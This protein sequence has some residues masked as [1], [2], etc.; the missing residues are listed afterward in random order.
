MRENI[1]QQALSCDNTGTPVGV[2]TDIVNAARSSTTPDVGAYEFTG[3]VCTSPPTAGNSVASLPSICSNGSVTLDLAG[4]TSGTGQTYQWQS[5]SAINGTYTNIS[6]VLANPAFT[7]SPTSTLFYKAVVTCNSLFDKS[8]A[9]Q[10]TVNP[11]LAS[12][13]YTIDP[14]GSGGFNFTTLTQAVDAL[15]CGIL[16]PV[17]FNVQPGT[18]NEQVTI[19][20]VA[21][22]SATNTVT[23]NGNGASIVFTSANTN[24]RA[25]ITLD[26]ADYI[27]INN[28]IINGS[29]GTYGW[30]I[31]LLNGADYNIISNN[32]INVLN[33]TNTAYN[34]LGICIGGTFTTPISASNAGNY[35]TISGNT[36]TGGY[37]PVVFYGSS[38][39]PYNTDNKVFNNIVKD[40]YSY[41]IYVYGNV[42]GIISRNDISRPTKAASTTT[43]GVFLSTGSSGMLVDKNTIH[44]MFDG[45][46]AGTSIFYGIYTSGLATVGNENKITNNLIYTPNGNGAV[47]GIYNST[48]PYMQAYHNT[49]SID[50]A[51]ATSGAAYGIYQTGAATGIDLRNNVISITRGGTGIKRC[52]YFVT[53]TSTITSN[54]NDLY[55]NSPGGTN[56]NLGQFGTTN[57]ASL[58]DWKTANGSIYDASSLSNDPQFTNAGAGNYA[59]QNS[60]LDN[61]GT[62]VGVTTDI[63]NLSRNSVTPDIGAYEFSTLTAGINMT[64]D[65]L[66]TPAVRAAGCYTDREDIVI[67]I[68]NSSLSEIN[69][70]N[71]PVTVTTNVTGAVTQTLSTVLNSGTLASDV[72]MDV[73]MSTPLDMTTIGTYTFNAYTTVAGDVNTAN[74]AIIPVTRTKIVLAAGNP[75][76]SPPAFCINGGKPTL[77]STGITGYSSLQWQ[78]SLTAGTGFTDLAGGTTSPFTVAANITQQTYYRLKAF[79]SVSSNTS[80]E[81]S[82]SITNHTDP[83]HQTRRKVQPRN[84]LTSRPRQAAALPFAGMQHQQEE[85]RWQQ[86]HLI[87]RL[88]SARQQPITFLLKLAAAAALPNWRLCLLPLIMVVAVEHF[89]T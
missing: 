14:G 9:V 85:R 8:S 17:V 57:Y 35:N 10:V 16:G 21:G 60:Q 4:N 29:A 27:R 80:S 55:L 32:T 50:D 12:G 56:N 15:K 83:D 28:F 19:P 26:G 37:Y 63:L 70:A 23:F 59:P 7:Y 1:N 3:P 75:V 43:A 48:S 42:N 41:S 71:N 62:P 87:Q 81:V 20:V 65:A 11:G 61:K 64:A 34:F 88:H 40:A 45:F 44:N 89:L 46:T 22:T 66:I 47:Y 86:G 73:T 38:A 77:S 24:Q 69:F 67:R 2:T 30:G 39:A 76:A 54:F 72:F 74:D 58:A 49:I 84:S 36:I 13:T 33:A 31:Q 18:Y 53:T 52:L 82:S 25:G 79:C 51:G 6:G 5:S 78:S 68:R